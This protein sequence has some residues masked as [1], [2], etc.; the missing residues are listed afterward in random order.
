MRVIVRVETARTS[1][2][3]RRRLVRRLREKLQPVDHRIDFIEAHVVPVRGQGEVPLVR[4][5]LRVQC[6][7]NREILT[8]ET[9]LT[10]DALGERLAEDVLRHV[11]EAFEIEEPAVEP[12]S[13]RRLRVIDPIRAA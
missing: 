13:R 7:G 2:E 6:A 9:D 11:R 4:C 8:S 5:R 1:L 10:L 3:A 12:R